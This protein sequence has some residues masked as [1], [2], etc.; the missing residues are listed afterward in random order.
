[1]KTWVQIA[2]IIL[3]LL[4]LAFQADIKTLVVKIATKNQ[5]GE[6]QVEGSFL[7]NTLNGKVW[8]YKEEEDAFVPIKRHFAA[9]WMLRK[10]RKEDKGE[11]TEQ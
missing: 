8:M 5:V 1:M 9:A 2:I 10:K 4:I 3:L 7:V 6:W 11:E